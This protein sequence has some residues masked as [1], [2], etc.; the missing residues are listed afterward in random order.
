MI[1]GVELDVSVSPYDVPTAV[2]GDFDEEENQ[3]VITF[4]YIGTEERTQRAGEEP[5]QMEIGR[6]SGRIY[7]IIVDVNALGA[8]AVGL[9][10]R[11]VNEAIE[12]YERELTSADHDN[13]RVARDILEEEGKE[14]LAAQ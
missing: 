5:V 1:K 3:F 8:E 7:R 9:N 13:F 2:H 14:L 11:K 10:L 12:G 6:Y 4:D